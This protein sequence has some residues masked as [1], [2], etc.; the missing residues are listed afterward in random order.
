MIKKL[1][2]YSLLATTVVI[3][4]CSSTSQYKSSGSS[5]SSRQYDSVWDRIRA[6]YNMP[7]LKDSRVDYWVDYYSK[8][9]GSVQTMANRSSK[10]IHYV[11]TELQKRGMPTELA[12]LPFV[13]S[14]YNTT[15]LS[16]VKASGLWQFMPAT[17]TDFNLAQ[18]W[19]RDE[20]R[21]PVGS[22]QAAINYLAY[23][24]NFQDNDWHLALAS[25]NWGQGS[26]RRARERNARQGLGTDYLSLRMPQETRDYVPKLMAFK[27]IISNPSRYGINLPHV[28]DQPYFEEVPKTVDIDIDVAARLAGMSLSEFKEMNPQ[29]HRPV[30]LAEH[31]QKVLIPKANVATYKRNLANYKGELASYTGYTPTAGESLAQI[32]ERY[33]VDLAQLKQLNGYRG[34]QHVAINSRTLMIPRNGRSNLPATRAPAAAPVQQAPMPAQPVREAAPGPDMMLALIEQTRLPA[35]AQAVPQAPRASTPSLAQRE[36]VPSVAAAPRPAPQPVPQAPALASQ[37]PQPAAAA[38]PDPLAGLLGADG[39]VAS[40]ARSLASN[41]A[42][43]SSAMPAASAVPAAAAASSANTA[44]TQVQY[45]GPVAQRVSWSDQPSAPT[46]GPRTAAYQAPAAPTARSAAASRNPATHRVA[47]GET[48]YSLARQY[49]TSVDDLAA[50]N[51]ITVDGLQAGMILRLPQSGAEG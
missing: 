3:S 43:S 17:G 41:Y 29:F 11:T 47:K 21:D 46:A 49:N 36:A 4:G 26:V 32:A 14:A 45:S 25:Y 38:Q 42:P 33:G 37:Q 39:S 2:I 16:R 20:R 13:E 12:L 9:P 50:L 18:N 6:G 34:N 15:A 24:Y 5:A 22:T 19:W 40:S 48:L 44:A 28:P 1:F 30:I 27:R 23:L 35:Q 8:R 7:D 51:N 10:Y 31:G